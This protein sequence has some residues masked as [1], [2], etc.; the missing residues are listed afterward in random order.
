MEAKREKKKYL[1]RVNKWAGFENTLI[2]KRMI[3]EINESYMKL[4]DLNYI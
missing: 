4:W 1:K 3:F 2:E